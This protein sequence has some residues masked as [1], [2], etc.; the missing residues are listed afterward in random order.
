MVRHNPHPSHKKYVLKSSPGTWKKQPVINGCQPM[1]FF[2]TIFTWEMMVSPNIWPDYRVSPTSISLKYPGS[3]S[4]F[5]S[6]KATNP[7]G[8]RVCEVGLA[9]LV[10][11]FARLVGWSSPPI[12]KICIGQNWKSSPKVRGENEKK[13][14]SCHPPTFESSTSWLQNEGYEL[15]LTTL[16]V[17][18]FLQHHLFRTRSVEFSLSTI[19]SWKNHPLKS[20]HL[21]KF[22]RF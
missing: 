11:T 3:G 14:L 16:P 5:P 7:W 10:D 6:K 13:H 4:H 9:D 12:W 1:G 22:D 19:A 17:T 21:M 8:A 20:P 18:H 2:C 15:F